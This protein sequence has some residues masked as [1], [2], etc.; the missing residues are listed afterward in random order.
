MNSSKLGQI[1]RG[2]KHCIWA[3]LSKRHRIK[4]RLESKYS[5]QH[6]IFGYALIFSFDTLASSSRCTG[7]WM[8]R[9]GKA[10]VDVHGRPH[11]SS[12]L[13]SLRDTLPF[14]SFSQSKQGKWHL[15]GQSHAARLL[16]SWAQSWADPLG[17]PSQG[18]QQNRL[19]SRLVWIFHCTTVTL[20]TRGTLCNR[21]VSLESA[22]SGR[23]NHKNLQAPSSE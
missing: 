11:Y 10:Q 9:I 2:R 5:V 7:R 13:S 23:R 14:T 12:P 3:Y 4:S 15:W 1:L 22:L 6:L 18:K 21:L 17:T 16:P 19:V 8:S 20:T